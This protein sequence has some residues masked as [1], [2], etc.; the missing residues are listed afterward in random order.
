MEIS[1]NFQRFLTLYALLKSLHSRG[2]LCVGATKIIKIIPCEHRV[3]FYVGL[4]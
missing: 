2:N 1:H 3:N 4:E